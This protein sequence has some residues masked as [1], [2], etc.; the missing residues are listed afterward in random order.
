M[1]IHTVSYGIHIVSVCILVQ[2]NVYTH[3]LEQYTH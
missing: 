1:C 2:K 3:L